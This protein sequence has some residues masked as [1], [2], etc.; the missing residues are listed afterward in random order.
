MKIK[1]SENT[2][3]FGKSH[4]L[5][6]THPNLSDEQVEKIIKLTNKFS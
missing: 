4:V 1:P 2:E 5:L 6:P 3:I